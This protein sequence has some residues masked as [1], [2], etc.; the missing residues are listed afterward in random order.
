MNVP[1]TKLSGNSMDQLNHNAA[2]L[3]NRDIETKQ[4]L[5]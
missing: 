5:E 2:T 3:I 1:N 4:V